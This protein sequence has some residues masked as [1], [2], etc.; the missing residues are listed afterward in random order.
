MSD[1]K[2]EGK[3]GRRKRR[4][5]WGQRSCQGAQE[6]GGGGRVWHQDEVVAVAQQDVE[7]AELEGGGQRQLQLPL[8]QRSPSLLLLL[9]SL[10]PIQTPTNFKYMEEV[11]FAECAPGE[12]LLRC[13]VRPRGGI[14][15]K[16]GNLE[17]DLNILLAWPQPQRKGGRRGGILHG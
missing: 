13:T 16:G 3:F 5:R 11:F 15:W 10:P 17:L 2:G 8:C 1:R 7:V 6:R 9:L 12:I 4:R 14:W